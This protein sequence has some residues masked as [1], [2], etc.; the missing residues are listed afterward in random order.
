MGE[1]SA[2]DPQKILL[3]EALDYS[4]KIWLENW[5]QLGESWFAIECDI[6][7]V[8]ML[9]ING[10]S[11]KVE[12]IVLSA[13]DKLNGINWKGVVEFD[14]KAY[15][16]L[17]LESEEPKWSMWIDGGPVNDRKNALMSISLTKNNGQWTA[18]DVENLA[19]DF[20]P[21]EVQVRLTTV[22]SVSA[23][24]PPQNLSSLSKGNFLRQHAIAFSEVTKRQCKWRL[25]EVQK[26][27]R[28]AANLGDLDV[29]ADLNHTTVFGVF[30][31][32]SCPCGGVYTWKATVPASGTPYGN[33]D[34]EGAGAKATHYLSVDETTDW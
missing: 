16:F 14:C 4:E 13:A 18:D 8:K 15:R 17:M 21:S 7:M 25:A 5:T 12:E 33:C 27:V 31:E 29:G 10:R 9:E 2:Q 34:F 1:Q 6:N 26:H 32:P 19:G 11:P 30:T 24:H 28:I 22:H 3:A 20:K 23:P